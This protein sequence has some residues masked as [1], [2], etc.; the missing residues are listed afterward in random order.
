MPAVAAA[1]GAQVGG[2]ALRL[3]LDDGR[4]EMVLRIQV[5]A[6]SSTD[7]LLQ[8]A[9]DACAE[10]VGAVLETSS[11]RITLRYVCA[12]VERKLNTK[13]PWE[14]GGAQGK[15]KGA[16]GI[17]IKMQPRGATTVSKHSLSLLD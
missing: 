1:G 9:F 13:V 11:K 8:A 16:V 12:D 10:A 5:G 7:A 15:L 4:P 14:V 17:I 2:L 3:I 6:I